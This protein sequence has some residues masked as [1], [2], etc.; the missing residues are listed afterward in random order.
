MI[1]SIVA[2]FPVIGAGLAITSFVGTSLLVNNA[3]HAV[4][5]KECHQQF[6]AAKKAGTVKEKT[7]REFKAANCKDER[8][9]KDEMHQQDAKKS[10]TSQNNTSS[11]S[12]AKQDATASSIA[13]GDAVFPNAVDSKYSNEKEG[14]ARMHTCL[15]QYKANKADNKN[16][17]L[18][19]IQKGGGYYS[20]CMKHFKSGSAQ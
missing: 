14:T 3:V 11:K 18:K 19:W 9:V 13:A 8:S 15:D 2:R 16:G 12:P 4:T 7:F 1:K 20:D 10:D 6:T 5:S 17:N